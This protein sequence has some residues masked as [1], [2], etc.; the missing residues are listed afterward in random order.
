MEEGGRG[1]ALFV[2]PD[3]SELAGKLLLCWMELIVMES[4]E[5]RGAWD[6]L[7]LVATNVFGFPRCYVWS[8][9]C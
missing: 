6:D 8:V 5:S 4:E 7:V 3:L 2:G 9:S 1:G